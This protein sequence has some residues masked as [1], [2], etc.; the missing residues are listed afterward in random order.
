LRQVARTPAASERATGMN[1]GKMAA[2]I[3][4]T[5]SPPSAALCPGR[6]PVLITAGNLRRVPETALAPHL[7]AAST[8]C[9]QI[10]SP[11]KRLRPCN[12]RS[13]HR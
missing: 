12:S 3:Q 7:D 2:T 5:L 9:Q 11:A 4:Q 8:D 1:A 10:R 6:E 13:A